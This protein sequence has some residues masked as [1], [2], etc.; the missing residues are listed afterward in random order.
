MKTLTTIIAVFLFI[1]VSN[2]S[3]VATIL[4]CL[5]ILL[6]ISVDFFDELLRETKNVLNYLYSKF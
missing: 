6:N 5:L 2:L 4:L 3:I 1:I